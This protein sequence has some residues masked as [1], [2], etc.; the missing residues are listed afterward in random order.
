[1]RLVIQGVVLPSIRFR[2]GRI[3]AAILVLIL[4]HGAADASDRGSLATEFERIR[5]HATEPIPEVSEELERETLSRVN[6]A[7]QAHG[8]GLVGWDPALAAVARFHATDMLNRE[9]FSHE[10][11]EGWNA[12]DRVSLWHRTAVAR[13]SEN[14]WLA[15]GLTGSGEPQ[16]GDTASRMHQDLMASPGHRANILAPAATHIGIGFAYDRKRL[17]AVQVIAE[18]ADYLEAPVA[19]RPT[20]GDPLPPLPAGVA[21][22][23]LWRFPA[24]PSAENMQRLAGRRLTAPPASYRVI[25]LP[26]IGRQLP[27]LAGPLIDLKR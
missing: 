25:V 26:A 23:G 1:M 14:I 11:P 2:H 3:L 13:V 6:A 27:I 24:P 20:Q 19:L 4:S 12:P 18:I 15:E 22:Y 16:I 5:Q 9:Y 10:S 8:L 7:R 17:L 21:G